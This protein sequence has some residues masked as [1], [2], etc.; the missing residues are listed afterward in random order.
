MMIGI[1]VSIMHAIMGPISTR[2]YI[3]GLAKNIHGEAVN[4]IHR[5]E[6]GAVCRRKLEW[7][8]GN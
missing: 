8:E 5:Q 6:I 3:H 1:T 4:K 7:M 2:P